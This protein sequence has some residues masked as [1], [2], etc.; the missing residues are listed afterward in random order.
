MAE[1][2]YYFPGDEFAEVGEEDKRCLEENGRLPAHGA[3]NGLA[4][5][6]GVSHVSD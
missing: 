1:S 6:A 5:T 2:V 4:R 3:R